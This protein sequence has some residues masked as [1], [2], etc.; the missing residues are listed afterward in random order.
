MI[1]QVYQAVGYGHFSQQ[2]HNGP[3]EYGAVL[4]L[5]PLKALFVLKL[6]LLTLF[7]GQLV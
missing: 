5:F 1:Q 3:R 2:T 4:L 7:K 6:L